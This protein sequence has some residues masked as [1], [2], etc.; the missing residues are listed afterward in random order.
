MDVWLNAMLVALHAVLAAVSAGH[1]LLYKRDSRAALGWIAVSV[2]FPYLGPLMYYLFGINRVRTRARR[3]SGEAPRQLSVGFEHA[4]DQ[5][6]E[7]APAVQLPD[8]YAELARIAATITRRS[9]CAGNTIEMLHNGE[10]VFRQ[11]WRRSMARGGR[12]T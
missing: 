3:L 1:A 12:F 10:Q 8:E 4:E 9:L 11:C 6:T 5:P 7:Q 2:V